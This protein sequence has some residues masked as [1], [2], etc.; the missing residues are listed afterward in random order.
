MVIKHVVPLTDVFSSFQSCTFVSSGVFSVF[1]M[2]VRGKVESKCG[3]PL[4][5][6]IYNES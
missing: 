1:M 3:I 4:K 2:N 5:F 6:F